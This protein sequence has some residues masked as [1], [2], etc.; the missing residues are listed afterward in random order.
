[1]HVRLRVVDDNLKDVLLAL[2]MVGGTLG[3]IWLGTWL[4]QQRRHDDVKRDA[5][6]KFLRLGREAESSLRALAD[7]GARNDPV[8][9]EWGDELLASFAVVEVVGSNHAA[10]AGREYAAALGKFAR[11]WLA[12][13]DPEI[14]AARDASAEGVKAARAKFVEA[15]RKD[16]G[17]GDE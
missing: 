1:M 2:L 11:A 3:G 17:V 5:Y 4:S 6:G 9:S 8:S 14:K 16:L 13:L 7:T 10:A 15:A 12:D